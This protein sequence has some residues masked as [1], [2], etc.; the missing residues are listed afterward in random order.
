MAFPDGR[1]R[2]VGVPQGGLRA[3]GNIIY[4]LRIALRCVLLSAASHLT[5]TRFEASTPIGEVPG[6]IMGDLLV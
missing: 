3:R 1:W 6:H 2:K 5:C 4:A